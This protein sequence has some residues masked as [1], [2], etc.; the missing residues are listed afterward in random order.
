MTQ[1]E[2]VLIVLLFRRPPD[3]PLTV[4]EILAPWRR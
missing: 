2:A 4:G 3:R 1:L